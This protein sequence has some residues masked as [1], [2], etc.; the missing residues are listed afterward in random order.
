[1][2]KILIVYGSTMGNTEKLTEKIIYELNSDKLEI[3]SK[4][5]ND[6]T[7]DE[8]FNYDILLF[9]SSTWGNGELQDDFADFIIKLETVN[10]TGK[11]G[12][13]F[14]PGD[15]S[16][17]KFCEA[18]TI[19]E[20]SVKKCGLMLYMSGLRI[21]GEIDD[22]EDLIKEWVNNLRLTIIND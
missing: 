9:G 20:E 4:N 12:A 10:L 21:D 6:A 15:S 19:I 7:V 18:V 2:K 5:V 3:T 17:D 8:L 11:K 14:G 1:M 22:S 13:V 16:Y